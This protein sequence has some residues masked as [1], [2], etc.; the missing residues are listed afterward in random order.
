MKENLYNKEI[1]L[2]SYTLKNL[3]VKNALE[4]KI[5]TNECYRYWKEK[6][7]NSESNNNNDVKKIYLLDT[8]KIVKSLT[9]NSLNDF[10][11]RAEVFINEVMSDGFLAEI[12]PMELFMFFPSLQLELNEY[13]EELKKK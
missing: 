6:T 10:L 7:I 2:K 12:D 1:K 11:Q 13:K 5:L 4:L 9:D 8:E 3:T